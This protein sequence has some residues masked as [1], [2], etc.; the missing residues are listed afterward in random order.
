LSGAVVAQQRQS[1]TYESK[2]RLIKQ[3]AIDTVK[4]HTGTIP[5]LFASVASGPHTTQA[6]LDLFLTAA[7]CVEHQQRHWELRVRCIST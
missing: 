6:P 2:H 3:L 1:D 5:S 7:S 4:L